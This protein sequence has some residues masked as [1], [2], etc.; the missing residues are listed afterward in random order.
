MNETVTI[1]TKRFSDL[2]LEELYGILRVRSEVFVTG[3]KCLYVDPDGRDFGSVQ[4]FASKGERIIAC[5]RIYGKEAGVVQIGRVAVIESLRGSGI[6]RMM[7]RQAIS[8]VT[9]NSTDEKIY[10]EAQTYAI[11]FY[12]K[13]G[14]KVISDE[15]LDE[16]IPH[17]GMELLIERVSGIQCADDA[18]KT[19]RD[20]YSLVYKQ[21]EALLEGEDDCIANMSNIAA[22][23]HS[24]FGFW[25]TGFYVVKGDELVLG[26]FQGPVACSRIPFGR[27]VCGT[28]WKRKE[29]IV[30]PDVE[31]F[32]GHIACSSLSRSEIVV[33]VLRGGNV[34]ALIDID[35]KELNTFDGIDREHLERI[36]DLIGKK[37]Q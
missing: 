17:K 8:Y 35:S 6:G 5:L 7:M 32:P 24:T 16:G 12:E 22:L 14:F 4:V 3:Q 1:T 25:W 21:V 10:L 26:P 33:P 13:L 27:G 15:F 29:S 31:Q 36:A 9:E 2:K 19:K 37:W 11:G 28:A 20:K 30:V 18:A 34:I 23:L